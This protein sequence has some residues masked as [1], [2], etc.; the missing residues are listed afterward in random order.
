MNNRQLFPF[1]RNRYYAGKMLA[2]MDFRAE[3]LYMNNKRRFLNSIA[4]GVLRS[5]IDFD[6]DKEELFDYGYLDGLQVKIN[7]LR[8]DFDFKSMYN[9]ATYHNFVILF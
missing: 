9:K 6:I 2:S 1:E 3:Q 8:I 5:V 4:G 7:V